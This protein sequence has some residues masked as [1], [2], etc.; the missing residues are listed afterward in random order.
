MKKILL[1]LTGILLFF[2]LL[3]FRGS[4]GNPTVPEIKKELSVAGQAFETSQE[5]SRLAI[6]LSLVNDRTFSIDRY[7]SIGTP[8]VGQING[9]YYSFF[10]PALSVI[11]IPFYLVGEKLGAY[12]L[13]IFSVS[14]L[15]AIATV[16]VMAFILRRL[17]M[18]WS[19]ILFSSIA[20]AF[21]TNAWGYSVTFYA[22]LASA[23]FILSGVAIVISMNEK[24]VFLK[25]LGVWTLYSLAVLIDFPNLFIFAPVALMLMS[26]FVSFSKVTDKIKVKIR[27]SIFFA[28]FVFVGLM[29]I[30]G[31]Y[32]YVNFGS[33]TKLSNTL[34]R[35][36]DMDDPTLKVP[37]KGGDAV[38]ALNTRNMLNGFQSF[39][40]SKDRGVLV[41]SPIALLF[42]FGFMFLKKKDEWSLLGLISVPATCLTLYTM[43]GD[44][45]G[46]WAFGSRYM[47]AVMPELCILAGIGLQ[48][49]SKRLAVKLF[50]SVVFIYS[51]AISL[52]APLTTNV[53]PPYIE[54][55]KGALDSWYILNIKMLKDDKLNSFVYNHVLQGQ[56]PGVFYYGFILTVLV[57]IGLF[58]IWRKKN[59]D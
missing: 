44:P 31:Y 30:Y 7:A 27:W 47:I 46:G 4:L 55:Q 11:A 24:R 33:P 17:K 22:H 50:Y 57:G 42:V 51:A 25:S 56:I 8:D 28:S 48:R 18:H 29:S 9:H 16:L 23:F 13:S 38:G 49:Y 54:S 39:V 59:N 53:V 43:F 21:A 40:I 10:P 52:L 14:T 32:N 37:E 58:L 19:V 1:I 41:Y 35:V 3:T 36:R 12:Q 34:P 15:F 20:F 26:K 45:Y 6:I 5:K 2:Y